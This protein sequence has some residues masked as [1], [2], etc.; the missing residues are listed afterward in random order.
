MNR[1]LLLVVWGALLLAACGGSPTATL[2]V[3]AS[4][5]VAFSVPSISF[6]DQFIGTVSAVQVITLSNTGSAGLHIV[7]IATAVPFSQTST[8][9]S[10]LPAGAQ[11]TINVTFSPDNESDFNGNVS[12]TDDAKGTPQTVTLTGTGVAPASPCVPVGQACGLGSPVCCSAPFP[13]H[14]FCSNPTGFGTCLMN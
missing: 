13:H 2:S 11:C 14:S 8:C 10:S 4:P 12:I 5:A 6:G 3:S 1:Y 7:G 9:T